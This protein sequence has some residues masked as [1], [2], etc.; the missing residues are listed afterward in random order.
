MKL[1]HL[2]KS[3]LVLF[4]ALAIFVV[5]CSKEDNDADGGIDV[6]YTIE[7]IFNNNQ[8]GCVEVI[9]T[10]TNPDGSESHGNTCTPHTSTTK[11]YSPGM[12]VSI[13]AESVLSF[14]AITVNIFK[15][16]V[17][18]KTHSATSTGLGDY[19]VASVSGT[20]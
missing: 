9:A 12:T 11:S 6:Y 8:E 18:W 14:S 3:L 1:L 10:M 7:G 16:G 19:A 15:N 2:W 20:L 17:L 4:S 13:T 5:S